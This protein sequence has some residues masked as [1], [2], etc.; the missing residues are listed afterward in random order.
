MPYRLEVLHALRSEHA[1]MWHQLSERRKQSKFSGPSFKLKTSLGD[2]VL[3]QRLRRGEAYTF[4]GTNPSS[5]MSILKTGFVLDL[6]GSSTGTMFGY[7]IYLAEC[8][9]KSDEYGRDDGGNTYPSINALLVCRTFVGNPL[10]VDKPGEHYAQQA[11]DNGFDSV[12]GDRESKVGTYREFICFDQR[13]VYPEYIIIYRRE[14]DRNDVPR[15]FAVPTTGSTGRNW[16]MKKDDWINL[17]PQVTK[18]LNEALAEG[19]EQ[20]VLAVGVGGAEPM[21]YSFNV[22]EKKATNTRNGHVLRLRAPYA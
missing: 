8:S 20:V 4:H 1:Y 22:A 11:A 6:A 2:T 10:V 19:R 21:E 16:Q 13:Q 7:G 3:T 15:E 17:A 12:V 5:A 9:S 18:I 14:Y